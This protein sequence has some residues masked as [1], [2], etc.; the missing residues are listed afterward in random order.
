MQAGHVVQVV[1]A[2]DP[3]G[4]Y[5][6]GIQ[7]HL[8]DAFSSVKQHPD[9]PATPP[10]QVPPPVLADT[11][12]RGTPATAAAEAPSQVRSPCSAVVRPCHA[13]SPDSFRSVGSRQRWGV[14]NTAVITELSEHACA[15]TAAR[16]LHPRATLAPL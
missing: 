14:I 12:D 3:F 8:D 6:E 9:E 4:Y 11:S 13:A 1:A 5:S 16:L 10:R 2:V 15:L 7:Q